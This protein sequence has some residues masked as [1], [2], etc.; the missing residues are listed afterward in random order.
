MQDTERAVE[1]L[2][3]IHTEMF[4]GAAGI[5]APL[6]ELLR[7]AR[8]PNLGRTKGG[9]GSGDM[10]DTQAVSM[11]ENIDGIV[12]AWLAHFREPHAGEL[13]PLTRRLHEVLR[14]EHAGGRLEDAEKLFSMFPQWVAQIDDYFDP[15][16]EY[17]LTAPCPECEAE[18]I[19]EGEEPKPGKPDE[20]PYKWA[21]RVPIKVGRAVVAECHACGRMWGGRDQLTQL[22]EAMSAEVDWA[23]LRELDRESEKRITTV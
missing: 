4:D 19:P 5:S 16:K 15:P 6:L 1:R 13:V 8:Y 12:R 21:V 10:L 22:G 9:G 18:R 3:E 11:Y 20:R 17:E 2:T 14:A 7:E 23:Q